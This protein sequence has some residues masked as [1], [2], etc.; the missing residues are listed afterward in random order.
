MEIS[1]LCI[2]NKQH[3]SHMLCLPAI[4]LYIIY[5]SIQW[6]ITTSS[7]I[8]TT[9]TTT[10]QSQP[11]LNFEFYGIYL[12]SFYQFIKYNRK[13]NSKTKKNKKKK[14]SKHLCYIK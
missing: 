5:E 7:L 3:E 4:I 8:E 11:A 9:A 2:S 6:P 1:L 13:F 14:N 10:S 12:L